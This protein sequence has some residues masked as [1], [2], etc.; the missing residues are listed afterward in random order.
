MENTCFRDS[1]WL[2]EN[3]LSKDTLMEYFSYSQFYDRN[4]NNEVLKMQNIHRNNDSL[5]IFLT[6][7]CGIQYIITYA[8][9]PTLFII[10]KCNRISPDKINVL[11]YFYVM[12]GTIY[13]SPTEKEVFSTR[14]TNILFSMYNSLES[15]PFLETTHLQTEKKK[16]STGRV[17]GL[18]NAY[19]TDYMR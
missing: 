12:N 18:F 5:D 19:Y 8:I 7:M 11:D 3:I 17:S 14:Y 13:Q 9:E 15:M 2:Q 16:I 1:L 4:C 6:K 10:K